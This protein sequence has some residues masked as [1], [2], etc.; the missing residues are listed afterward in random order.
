M[1]SA[2]LPYPLPGQSLRGYYPSAR[3]TE[4]FRRCKREKKQLC[5]T[6]PPHAPPHSPTPGG[7]DLGHP[8][9]A[10]AREEGLPLG[11]SWELGR[12][13]GSGHLRSP[14]TTRTGATKPS[15][16]TPLGQPRLLHPGPCAARLSTRTHRS[17]RSKGRIGSQGS[18]TPRGC[19]SPPVLPRSSPPPAAVLHGR[20]SRLFF[21]G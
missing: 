3:T 12:S 16:P 7:G 14:S 9:G 5:R 18:C 20:V 2:L 1:F 10:S 11:L 4:K 8:E 6:P 13:P 21:P 15:H 17:V 19:G